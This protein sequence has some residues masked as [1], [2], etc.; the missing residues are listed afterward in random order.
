MNS[1]VAL[2][3]VAAVVVVVGSLLVGEGDPLVKACSSSSSFV[4]NYPDAT[5]LPLL[6][7]SLFL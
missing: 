5:L 2:A 4:D 7:L 1:M 6:Y 3:A